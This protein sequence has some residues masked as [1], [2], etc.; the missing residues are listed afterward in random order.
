MTEYIL[1]METYAGEPYKLH[2]NLTG[3]CPASPGIHTIKMSD[4][5]NNFNNEPETIEVEIVDSSK[6][7]NITYGDFFVLQPNGEYLQEY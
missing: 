2:Y 6:I 3:T 1:V 5:D 4:P 7:F